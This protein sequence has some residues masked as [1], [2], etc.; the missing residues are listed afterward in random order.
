MCLVKSL[1]V[2]IFA[3]LLLKAVF[4]PLIWGNE[5]MSVQFVC[6]IGG[7]V[8]AAAEGKEGGSWRGGGGDPYV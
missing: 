7:G 5:T 2:I 4:S 1:H 8:F 6:A 3:A